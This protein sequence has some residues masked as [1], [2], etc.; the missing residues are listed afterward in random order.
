MSRLLNSLGF[1]V[2]FLFTMTEI[3][4]LVILEA[5][6]LGLLGLWAV[7]CFLFFLLGRVKGAEVER[8]R[9]ERP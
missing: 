2:A 5:L 7:S 8:S 1:S 3:S 4:A 6:G 9:Q